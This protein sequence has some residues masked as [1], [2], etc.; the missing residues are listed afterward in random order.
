MADRD[1]INFAY[2][3]SQFLISAVTMRAC[4]YTLVDTMPAK[5]I[6]ICLDLPWQRG[7]QRCNFTS[8][9]LKFIAGWT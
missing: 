6:G 8:K 1:F 3:I 7:I 9:A 5:K 4:Y 2:D